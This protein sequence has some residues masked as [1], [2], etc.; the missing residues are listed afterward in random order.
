MFAMGA[1]A[2]ESSPLIRRLLPTPLPPL[3]H[4]S[5][6]CEEET[7]F[8]SCPSVG[9]TARVRLL[10]PTWTSRTNF[11]TVES[12]SS[13]SSIGIGFKKKKKNQKTISLSPGNTRL[14]MSVKIAYR[15]QKKRN[16]CFSQITIAPISH[17]L[18]RKRV[19]SEPRFTSDNPPESSF[20]EWFPLVE[21]LSC[22]SS[23][24]AFFSAHDV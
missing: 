8:F 14:T 21:L 2:D 11:Y 24:A 15:Q 13:V 4:I 17:P 19:E 10:L 5:V 9:Q 16:F 18:R 3:G 1:R 23:G 7:F 20:S 22:G 12:R 6:C